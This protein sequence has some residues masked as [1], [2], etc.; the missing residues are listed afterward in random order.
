[1]S[2]N[3][4]WRAMGIL[5]ILVALGLVSLAILPVQG[6]GGTGFAMFAV[7]YLLGSIFGQ[8]VLAAAWMALGPGRL[9]FRAPLSLA[10]CALLSLAF[11]INVML[12]SPSNK[13]I[14]FTMAICT[15]GIWL[16]AQAPFWCLRWPGGLHIERA[17]AVPLGQSPPQYG[18][19]Q[20]LIFTTI[21]A[22]I[23][24]AGRAAM[25][26]LPNFEQFAVRGEA[27]IFIALS[28]AAVLISLPLVPAILLSRYALLAVSGVIALIVLATWWELPLFTQ[29][30]GGRRGP[31][32]MHFVWI[33]AATSFWILVIG[34]ILRWGGYRLR[35]TQSAQP[36]TKIQP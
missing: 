11:A 1:M 17:T 4:K 10:W 16:A 15:G 3:Q 25:M 28:V 7:G 20:L 13:E 9:F 26:L 27:G 33:N 21:V 36:D 29:F 30:V 22:A 2:I 32:F 19:G 8:S 12:F 31:S 6:G 35:T 34:L 18:I 14:I 23:F 5:A 24:G